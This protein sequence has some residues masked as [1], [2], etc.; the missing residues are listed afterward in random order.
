MLKTIFAQET[1]AEAKARWGAVA[2]ALHE[3]N[4]RLGA[5]MDASRD[6]LLAYMDWPREHWPQ[7]SS[8]TPTSASTSR[9]SAAQTPSGSSPNDAAIIRLV[10]A[11]MIE[12]NDEWAFRGFRRATGATVPSTATLHGAG[13]AGPHRRYS[14]RQAA[15]RGL[16]TS[17]SLSEGR[18]SYTM[19]RGTTIDRDLAAP[20]ADHPDG[21]LIRSLPGMGAVLAAGFIA[22]TGDTRRFASAG[23]PASATGLAPVQRQSGNRNGWPRAP[24]RVA[25][26]AAVSAHETQQPRRGAVSSGGGPPEP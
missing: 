9:S 12:T 5:M 17:S 20:L 15:H 10:G 3:K 19:P 18:P 23:A 22:Y 13:D 6:D 7:I 1:R 26:A 14:Q 8:T 4:D 21:A 24:R 11:L 25:G 16:L 2:D